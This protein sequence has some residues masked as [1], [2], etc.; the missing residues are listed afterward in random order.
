MTL[1]PKG[2]PPLPPYPPRGPHTLHIV[3]ATIKVIKSFH[4]L[5]QLSKQNI[6]IL[7][8]NKDGIDKEAYSKCPS[9]LTHRFMGKYIPD[10]LQ[11][12]SKKHVMVE[13]N[14]PPS[15]KKEKISTPPKMKWRVLPQRTIS[16]KPNQ[17][18][19][20]KSLSRTTT[21]KLW[22]NNYCHANPA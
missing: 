3:L 4:W 20:T 17:S 6:N 11:W 5:S 7:L 12:K 2:H 18:I 21:M 8:D 15:K 22:A 13:S 10:L 16:A 14:P 1:N 19:S 9:S